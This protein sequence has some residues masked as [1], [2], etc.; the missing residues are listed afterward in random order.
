M[1]RCCAHFLPGWVVR[2]ATGRG[3]A[4]GQ[5]ARA[6]NPRRLR[7]PVLAI[8][9]HSAGY[10]RVAGGGVMTG[11]LLA[12]PAGAPLI[13]AHRPGCRSST[14]SPIL[15]LDWQAPPAKLCSHIVH[16]CHDVGQIGRAA[17]VG[18]CL[19]HLVGD[20][21]LACHKLHAAMHAGQWGQDGILGFELH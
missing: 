8:Y 18:V 2:D 4:G 20:G 13:P 19:E 15:C 21:E 3:G 6:V 10:A 9:A 12:Q 7:R 16:Y 5:Q 1:L 11:C 14:A 17:V